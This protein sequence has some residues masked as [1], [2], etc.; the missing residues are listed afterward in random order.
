MAPGNLWNISSLLIQTY[1]WSLGTA[2]SNLIFMK[3]KRKMFHFQFALSWKL[4]IIIILGYEHVIIIILGYDLG[5]D[6]IYV[7]M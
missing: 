6:Y 2:Y 3:I 7:M 1:I 5:C 4:V